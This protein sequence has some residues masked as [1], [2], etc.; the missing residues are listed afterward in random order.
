MFLRTPKFSKNNR[1]FLDHDKS[2]YLSDLQAL[3]RSHRIRRGTYVA[4]D[5]V[6]FAQI[7]EYRQY[8]QRLSSHQVVTTRLEEGYLEY[9]SPERQ[10]RTTEGIQSD[11]AAQLLMDGI[12]LSIYLK[13]PVLVDLQ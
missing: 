4:A 6:I 10:H 11:D 12:E 3:E 2:L 8:M 7:D 13:D 1:S 9:S 5:N